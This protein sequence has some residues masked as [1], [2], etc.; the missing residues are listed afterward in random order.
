MK[1]NKLSFFEY[2]DGG[3]FSSLELDDVRPYISEGICRPVDNDM[4]NFDM[5]KPFTLDLEKHNL[6]SLLTHQTALPA[7]NRAE[8]FEKIKTKLKTD[9]LMTFKPQGE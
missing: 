4:L 9:K 8:L 1:E 2:S 6:E 3:G 5:T 7:Y